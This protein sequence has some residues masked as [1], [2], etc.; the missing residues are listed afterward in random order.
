MKPNHPLYKELID[1]Y[2]L[3]HFFND[4]G[5]L[6][7]KTVVAYTSECLIRH[8]LKHIDVIQ[9][10]AGIYIY[11]KEYFCPLNYE[12]GELNIT[13][14][15]KSIHHYDASWKSKEDLFFHS[16][17]KCLIKV[18]GKRI[19]SYTAKA[20]AVIR[21]RGLNGLANDVSCS[22]KRRVKK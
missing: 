3:R 18:I 14:K 9:E 13:S 5:T 4:D 7:L 21:F 1:G 2:R 8:G 6:N 11:P 15:T 17:R 20:I 19:G 16:V 10:I 22:I 12:I